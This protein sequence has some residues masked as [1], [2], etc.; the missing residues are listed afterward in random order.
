MAIAR[1]SGADRYLSGPSATAYLDEQMF[2]AAGIAV[3]WM[4]Y[5]GYPVYPQL[6]G[7]FEHAVSVLDLLFSTGPEARRYLHSRPL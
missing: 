3:E 1:A 4:S 6:H 7:E 5:E 2:A